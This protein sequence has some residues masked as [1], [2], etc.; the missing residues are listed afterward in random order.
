MY[1][2]TG[3]PVDDFDGK[4]QEAINLYAIAL[5]QELTHYQIEFFN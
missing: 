5:F 1:N 4:Q 2:I 3:G